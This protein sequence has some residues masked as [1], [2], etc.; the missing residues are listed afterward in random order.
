[1]SDVQPR[2]DLLGA[3]VDRHIEINDTPTTRV[4]RVYPV[5]DAAKCRCP[6]C[7]EACVVQRVE[8]TEQYEPQIVVRME[9][10]TMTCT[11]CGAVTRVC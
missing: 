3:I 8:V 11:E 1:M 4:R 10:R 7:G 9:P 2:M 6:E 5:V